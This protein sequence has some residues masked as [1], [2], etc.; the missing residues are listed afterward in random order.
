MV[1]EMPLQEGEN[2]ELVSQKKQI[3]HAFCLFA[4]F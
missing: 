2:A 3:F 1:L 4:V